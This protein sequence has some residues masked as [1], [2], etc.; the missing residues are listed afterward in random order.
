MRFENPFFFS[1]DF[2]FI[3]KPP[4]TVHARHAREGSVAKYT[5]KDKEYKG[6][7]VDDRWGIPLTDANARD[8]KRVACR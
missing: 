5:G 3:S 8:N 1:I 6:Q 2:L 7:A 4:L